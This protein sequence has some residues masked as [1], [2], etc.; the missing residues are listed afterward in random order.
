VPVPSLSE[1]QKIVEIVNTQISIVDQT[2]SIVDAV[3]RKVS[4]LRRSLLHAA[5]TGQLTKEW[6]EGAHV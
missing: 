6:R 1:Q 3:D 2:L 4:E 5:F